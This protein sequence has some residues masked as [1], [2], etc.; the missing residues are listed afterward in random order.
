[1]LSDLKFEIPVY[2][3]TPAEE[4]YKRKI[5][6]RLTNKMNMLM[7]D[8]EHIRKNIRRLN[9]NNDKELLETA[10]EVE[11]FIDRYK[12]TFQPEANALKERS[13]FLHNLK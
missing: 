10:Q 9:I 13:T 6:N 3:G 5:I 1:M 4:A 7:D 8:F 11:T 12:P 2:T